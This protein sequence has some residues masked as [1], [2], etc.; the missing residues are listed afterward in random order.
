MT[1]GEIKPLVQFGETSIRDTLSRLER[2][3]KVKADRGKVVLWS[4]AD[5]AQR[6][7]RREGRVPTT[8]KKAAAKTKV[9]DGN[10][11]DRKA[12]AARDEKVLKL[13]QK[14]PTGLSKNEVAAK[15]ELPL[16]LAYNS[17]SR[18]QSNGEATKERDGSRVPRW[19]AA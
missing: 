7:E 1:V 12:C 19:K 11:G 4:L 10:P 5:Q 9:Y 13:L 14:T 3:G 15:L 2:A 6:A 17:L 16:Q 8:K 18:L